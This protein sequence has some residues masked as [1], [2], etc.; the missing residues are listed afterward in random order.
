MTP[1]ATR[2]AWA[3]AWVAGLRDARAAR[4]ERDVREG[5]EVRDDRDER[6]VLNARET[7]DVER[8]WR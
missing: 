8:T 7:A 4:D 6:R 5:R 3:S 1:R 2:P